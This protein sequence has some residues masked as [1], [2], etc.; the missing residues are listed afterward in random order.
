MPDM[1]IFLDFAQGVVNGK[2]EDKKVFLGLISVFVQ[3]EDKTS[4]GVGMQ[5]FNYAPGYLE[6]M[7]IAY[8]RSPRT[9]KF[10]K[11]HFPAPD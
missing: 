9:F 10:L 5:N 4:R 8:I 1:S 11:S 7:H 3:A 6:F 2:Y